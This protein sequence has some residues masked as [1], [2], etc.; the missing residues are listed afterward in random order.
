MRSGIKIGKF[1]CFP[2]SDGKFW[3]DGGA[4]FG[5][6][7]KIFWEKTN[8]SDE[9]NRILLGLHPLLIKHPESNILVDTGIGDKFSE[10][11]GKIYGVDKSETLEETLSECGLETGDIDKVI[12]THLHFDHAGGNTYY[13]EEGEPVVKFK[14]ASYIIQKKEW[15]AALKPNPRSKASYLKD[16]FLPIEENNQLKLIDGDEEIFPGI[17]C[18]LT[19][20][21]TEGHQIVIIRDN[22]KGAIY[23]A[24]LIPT[25]SHIKLPYIMGY[26]LFPLEVIDKKKHFIKMAT[27]NKYVSFFEHDPNKTVGYI[28]EK[29]GKPEFVPMEE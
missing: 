28:L 20:G 15:E 7:P 18:V 13:S 4:M 6:V 23:W 24:D 10:K 2:L 8:P 17:T 27:E 21:H 11:F 9:K 16:N 3:L 19:G 26:D 14:N 12:I 22:G 29:E 1:E 5:V 25:T